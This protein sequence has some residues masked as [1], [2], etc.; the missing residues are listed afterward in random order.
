MPTAQATLTRLGLGAYWPTP[1]MAVTQHGLDEWKDI[2]Y[3]A[4]DSTADTDRTHTFTTLHGTHTQAYLPLKDWGINP[5]KY[6]F[7]VGEEGRRGMRVPERYLDD[8]QDLKGTRLKLL[9]RTGILPVMDRI[10]REARP[11]WPKPLRTCGACPLPVVEDVNHFLLVC[12]LYARHRQRMLQDVRGAL[13]RPRC[14]LTVLA[15]NALTPSAK[16]AVLLGKR[17]G[18]PAVENI[19]DRATKRFLKKAWNTRAPY[20]RQ[21]NNLLNLHISVNQQVT[22]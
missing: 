4:V 22:Y 5:P 13:S 8:R 12:P 11:P 15:F 3:E 20:T 16:A 2:V 17:I 1:D 19:I 6:A 18:A 14:P 10:G 9:C 7:S 21:I